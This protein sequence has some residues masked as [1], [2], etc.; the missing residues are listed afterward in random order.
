M[1]SAICGVDTK[2]QHIDCCYYALEI[3][4][5]DSKADVGNLDITELPI[6]YGTKEITPS[7]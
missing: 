1:H 4:A 2:G 6:Y 5:Q 7:S 3:L